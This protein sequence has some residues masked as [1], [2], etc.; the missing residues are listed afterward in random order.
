MGLDS[1]GL[2]LGRMITGLGTNL[3][4]LKNFIFLCRLFI[5]AGFQFFF[6]VKFEIGFSI[7]LIT[8]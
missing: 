1:L 7:A 6:G 3:D 8:D 4:V 2:G 5:G